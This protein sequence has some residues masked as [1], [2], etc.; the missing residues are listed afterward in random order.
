[1]EWCLRFHLQE[2]NYWSSCYSYEDD[3]PVIAIADAVRQRGFYTKG[4]FLEVCAW[5]A[6]RNVPRCRS[7]DD[8]FV[9]Y[10]T[11]LALAPEN[12]FC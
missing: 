2:I 6:K 7:N 11:R 8:D 3:E 5:K 10:A 9:A 1:M 12:R 4:D